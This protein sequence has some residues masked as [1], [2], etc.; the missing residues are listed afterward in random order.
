MSRPVFELN[1]ALVVEGGVSPYRI[2]EAVD[3]AGN[4]LFGIVSGLEACAP[5][6]LGFEGLEKVSTMAL[7]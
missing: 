7:S 1:G 3:V 2:V 4:G 5:D 6:E